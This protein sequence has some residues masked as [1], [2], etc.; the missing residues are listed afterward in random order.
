MLRNESFIKNR[1]TKRS[2]SRLFLFFFIFSGMSFPGEKDGISDSLLARLNVSGVKEQVEAYSDL[3]NYYN[4]V[5]PEKSISYGEKAL[6]IAS[7]AHY[8]KGEADILYLL[9]VGYHAQTENAKAM[10]YYEL[11]YTIRKEIKD[12]VG[13]GE[14]LNRIGLI[15][16][17]L[18]NYE[19]ALDY[20]LQSV[21]VLEGESDK[22]ALA[23]AYNHLGIIY[24]ILNDIP[25]AKQN[26]LK[27]M[28]FCKTPNEDLVLAVS[29][30]Y[31]GIIY[32]KLKEYDK[33]IYH[34][35]K[36]LELRQTKNDRIGIAGS[37]ENMAIISR[38]CKEYE[39]A[40]EYYTRSLE[41]KKELNNQRGA[42]SSISGIGVT[43]F[44]MG[45]YEKSLT[46]LF[47]AFEKRKQFGDKR[48]IVSTLNRV[49]ETYAAMK[50]YKSALEY[51]RLAKTYSDSLLSEQKN[52]AIA[53]FQESFQREKRDKEILLLQKENTLQKYLRNFLLVV[54]ILFSAM[55]IIVYF[56]Y[57]SKR[58]VNRLLAKNNDEM[59]EQKEELL[60]LNEQLRELVTTK[61]KFFSIIA[62]DL[63]SPF[64]GFLGLTQIFAEDADSLPA[65]ELSKLGH[66]MHATAN[67]LFELLK[68]LLEWAQMQKGSIFFEPKENSINDLVVESL[69]A[70]KVRS[71][72][73][74]ISILNGVTTP[75]YAFVDEKMIKSVLQNL[76][77]NAVKFTR[78]GGTVTIKAKEIENNM[79]EISVN[80]TGVG[81]RQK[82]LD[83]LFKVGEKIGSKGTDG[84]LSTGLGLLLCKEFVEKHG[85]KI[86]AESVEGKGSTLYF[87]VP[88]KE[89]IRFR[90]IVP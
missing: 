43:Y 51:D 22:K 27:A 35:Q 87:T 8:R 18:G 62:H 73:K 53:E 83:K 7:S 68:N 67:N 12:N 5:M 82:E 37:Y 45:Q 34:T 61:D 49:A 77:S 63:K 21:R 79:V 66:E 36:G 17:A 72:Q 24:Y 28:T 11:A 15:Y 74:G 84:E 70:V 50:N 47:R 9:G 90:E 64:L 39:K 75:V 40:L 65:D 71:A 23:Q 44:Y 1:V 32:I 46:F 31:M 85:G 41:I 26:T 54:T 13:I 4:R 88:G 30:E 78:Q 80:D 38:N 33:A 16:N 48:G 20:C 2:L 56:A 69:N 55:A 58:K 29:H 25:K 81:I 52:R 42:A 60:R 19:K 89:P 10:K 57:R 76:F 86:R 59:T 14:C 3:M 6:Q